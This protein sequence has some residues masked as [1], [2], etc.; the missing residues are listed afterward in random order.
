MFG[1]EPNLPVDFLLGRV[2]QPT[3]WTVMD[4]ME[5]HRERLQVAFNGTR[6]SI[7][8][9]ARLRKERH[10]QKGYS[11]HLKE[12]QLVYRRDYSNRGRNKIQDVWSLIKYKVIQ[13]PMEGGTVYSIALPNTLARVKRVHRTMLKPVPDVFPLYPSPYIGPESLGFENVGSEEMEEGQWI[14]VLPPEETPPA[15]VPV[16]VV[17]PTPVTQNRWLAYCILM[18][19]RRF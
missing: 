13:A 8:A 15:T 16:P 14:R 5:E 4:W 6:E 2:L 9:A 7:Q 1:K 12:G 17:P 10:Y 18:A 11:C 3:V 19:G